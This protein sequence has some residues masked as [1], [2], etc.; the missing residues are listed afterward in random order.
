MK[1]IYIISIIAILLIGTI[2]IEARSLDRDTD[3][4][5]RRCSS[6]VCV[7]P[8]TQDGGQNQAQSTA[9]GL[10]K[11][12]LRQEQ[13]EV[14]ESCRVVREDGYISNK[15]KSACL[16]SAYEEQLEATPEFT[17]KSHI[18]ELLSLGK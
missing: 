17:I 18:E 4:P 1:K 15:D 12:Y 9:Y 5:K 14:W 3:I 10:Y 2:L 8:V 16:K 11:R 7:K 6:I 13:P